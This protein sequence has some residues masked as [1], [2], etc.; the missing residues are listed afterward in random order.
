M[1]PERGSP[2]RHNGH[3]Q[4]NFEGKTPSL[5]YPT[6]RG[7]PGEQRLLWPF[8]VE[9]PQKEAAEADMPVFFC[10]CVPCCSLFGFLEPGF[11]ES[12]MCHL[13]QVLLFLMT[14]LTIEVCC[15]QG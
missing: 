4:D 7:D 14:Q 15:P 11:L 5:A 3:I 13:L 1:V 8:S 12:S 6:R 9:D 10:I 2:M